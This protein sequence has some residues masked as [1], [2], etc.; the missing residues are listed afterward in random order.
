[1]KMIGLVG[2][3]SDSCK[4]RQ[5]SQGKTTE[6]LARC[7]ADLMKSGLPWTKRILFFGFLIFGIT[8]IGFSEF[9]SIF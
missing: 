7:Q 2:L 5:M 9:I 6:K 4:T 8:D 1:M 3:V